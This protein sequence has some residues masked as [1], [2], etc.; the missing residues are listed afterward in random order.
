[1]KYLG[2]A[3]A[4]LLVLLPD[5]AF[6]QSPSCESALHA[7][8]RM[9]ENLSIG[10]S[11][12]GENPSTQHIGNDRVINEGPPHA[13]L[14]AIILHPALFK[15][16]MLNIW[17]KLNDDGWGTIGARGLAYDDSASGTI[18]GLTNRTFVMPPS[19]HD[20]IRVSINKTDGKAKTGITICS[21]GPGGETTVQEAAFTF[22]NNKDPSERNFVISG[23]RDRVVSILMRNYSVANKFTY[24]IS[25]SA[26]SL[27]PYGKN[28]TRLIG[29]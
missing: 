29:C 17:N 7:V 1:M 21:V 5:S 12:S 18:R 27:K 24:D 2:L 16:E 19:P 10:N 3:L 14:D 4:F 20:R 22:E 15:K 9:W 13:V 8:E 25:S 28:C 11:N 23:V 26:A 6:S